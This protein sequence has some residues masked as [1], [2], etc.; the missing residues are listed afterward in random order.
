MYIVLCY[1]VKQ[2]RASRMLKT[3]KKYLYHSQKSVFEGTLTEAQLKRLQR[4]ISGIIVQDEDA[5]MIYRIETPSAVQRIQ[6]G[7][8]TTAGLDGI[9]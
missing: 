1:D 8:I 6:Q 7:V 5:I 3:A 9:L 2:K 4:E